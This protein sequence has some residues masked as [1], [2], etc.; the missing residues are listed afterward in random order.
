MKTT[1]KDMNLIIDRYFLEYKELPNKIEKSGK[2][3]SWQVYN[4]YSANN[5]CK[6]GLKKGLHTEVI[7]Y[8]NL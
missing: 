1:K 4:C 7:K 6:I 5:K 2:D 3:D 8:D